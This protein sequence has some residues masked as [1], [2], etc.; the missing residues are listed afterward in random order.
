M[1]VDQ[2]RLTALLDRVVGDL[3]AG[4]GGVMVR[5]GDALGLYAAMAGA[6]P[7]T[8]GE[9]AERAG[10]AERYVAEWLNA[11]AAG[12]YVEY[13]PV[14]GT[15]ELTAEAALVLADRESPLFVPPAWSVPASM[16]V[17][18]DA[19]AEAVRTGRGVPW[20]DRHPDLHHGIAG[21]YRNAYRTNIAGDWIP[22]LDGIAERLTAGGAVA[23][24]GCG[25]GH[26]AIAIAEAFP[27]AQ[28]DGIDSH[29]AS[30]DQARLYARDA[31][32]GDRVSFQVADARGYAGRGYDLICFFDALHDMGDPEAVLAHAAEALAP[33]GAVL[34]VEPYAG[35]RV[36]D[37]LNPVGRLY[38][39]ASVAICLAHGHSEGAHALGAQAGE[40]R[41]TEICRRAGLTRVRRAAA[42]PFN[43]ILEARV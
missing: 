28:V 21:F 40:A 3:S 33:G 19:T 14:S 12:G 13:H 35:D 41:L 43:L 22:A 16:F 34:L 37:N 24:V 20:G 15:Y 10:C 38:Y 18:A 11:Q 29:A 2:E 4:Y 5:I 32:V 26:S 36:E 17:D 25:H 1:Q 31:G 9:V 27:A 30:I 7:L 6:G 8:P 23:D 39:S 42:T